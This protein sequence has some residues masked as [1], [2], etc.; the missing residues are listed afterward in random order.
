MAFGQSL[1][2]G[3]KNKSTRVGLSLY[4]HILKML[5]NVHSCLVQFF[6][7]RA[8]KS[9]KSVAMLARL[10]KLV[11]DLQCDG[12]RDTGQIFCSLLPNFDCW[13]ALSGGQ[14]GTV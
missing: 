8:P 2:E 7:S 13:N 12:Q 9:L 3:P 4:D 11:V 1:S 5:T 10:S 14:L 6:S